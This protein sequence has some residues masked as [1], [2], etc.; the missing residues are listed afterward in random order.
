MR[1]VGKQ[2]S[3]F[4]G[5]PVVELCMFGF[6]TTCCVLL[7]SRGLTQSVGLTGD[8]NNVHLRRF[9]FAFTLLHGIYDFGSVVNGKRSTLRVRFVFHP[10]RFPG[11]AKT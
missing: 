3:F 5:E 8:F 10:K 1:C 4:T 9:I 2:R 6:M 11:F 7:F